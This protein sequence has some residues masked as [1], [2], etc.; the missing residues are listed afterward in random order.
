MS[1]TRAKNSAP[2]NAKP[3]FTWGIRAT[4]VGW[5]KSVAA[6]EGSSSSDC[7]ASAASPTDK[8]RRKKPASNGV[9]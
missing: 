9:A 3:S 1:S 8:R 5:M 6:V 4:E 7:T 2:Q